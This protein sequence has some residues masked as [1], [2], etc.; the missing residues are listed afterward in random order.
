MLHDSQIS[1]AVWDRLLSWR[2][3]VNKVSFGLISAGLDGQ[4]QPSLSRQNS[5]PNAAGSQF[6]I[7]SSPL[8]SALF[9]RWLVVV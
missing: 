4:R 6:M 7:T 2:I 3:V 8:T 5:P 1:R 9:C